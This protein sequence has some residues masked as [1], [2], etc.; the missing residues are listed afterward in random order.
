MA[1]VSVLVPC[2]RAARFVERALDSVLAQTRG[3]WELV[4]CDNAS[5]DGT[6]EILQAYAARDA[7]IRVFRND[8]NIGPV[9]NWRRC[10][11]LSLAPLAGLLFAD[12][13]YE[14]RFLE[15]TVGLLDDPTVG[16]AYTAVRFVQDVSS[17]EGDVVA[18]TLGERK[19]P[20]AAFLKRV[21]RYWGGQVPV[22]PGCAL[23]RREDLVRWLS[24]RLEDEEAFGFMRHGAGPDVWVYLQACREYP[25]VA[26]VPQPLVN[27][28]SHGQNLSFT[29]NTRPAYA[30]ALVQFAEASKDE[31]V[32]RQG[33]WVQLYLALRGT[34][35]A[36]R[37]LQ[38]LRLAGKLRLMKLGFKET[39]QRLWRGIQERGA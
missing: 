34:P 5:G 12:D 4:A 35:Y 8:E 36:A 38:Q 29:E 18:Y 19:V 21:L 7:R 10:A 9:G 11:S 24:V 20:S 1:T 26:H 17:R 14:P 30:A 16:L 25:A 28:F 22:S 3:D 13:W 2:Y 15:D 33:A 39:A 31:V 37:V 27:F 6:W 32:P 23:A